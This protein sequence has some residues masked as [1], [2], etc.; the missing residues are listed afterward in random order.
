MNMR[1]TYI[2]W[3][4]AFLQEWC[5]C[6]SLEATP[7]LRAALENMRTHVRTVTASNVMSALDQVRPRTTRPTHPQ[8]RPT[9]GPPSRH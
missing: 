8:R 2:V 4:D 9:A 6:P 3:H 5:A 1:T 7:G